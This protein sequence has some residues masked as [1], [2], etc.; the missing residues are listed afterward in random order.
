[1]IS[2]HKGFLRLER[3]RRKEEE[4]GKHHF[5]LS[6]L[7][8]ESKRKMG[9]GGMVEAGSEKKSQSVKKKKK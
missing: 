3:E 8:V 7:G 5:K 2:Q 9:V 1:M 6:L 4:E